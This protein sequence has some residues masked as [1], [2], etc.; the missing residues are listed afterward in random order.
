MKTATRQRMVYA[1]LVVAI[2]WG[3]Y[4]LLWT[5]S[6]KPLP[7]VEVDVPIQMPSSSTAVQ[8]DKLDIDRIAAVKWGHDPFKSTIKARGHTTDKPPK[9]LK[10]ILSG[11]VYNERAPMAVINRKTVRPGDVIDNA[12]V[13]TI[14]EKTVLMERNGKRFTLRVT[15]G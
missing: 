14:N 5:E 10:W 15:K 3:A 7:P 8:I 9:D 4:N 13:V 1:T 6:R 11:I 12:R 2:I